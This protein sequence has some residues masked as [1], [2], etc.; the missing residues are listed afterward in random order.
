[1]TRK[2]EGGIVD[3]MR[4]ILEKETKE[5]IIE[6]H[7]SGLGLAGRKMLALDEKSEE[8]DV[9]KESIKK[10]NAAGG[11]GKAKKYDARKVIFKEAYD[12]MKTANG[13]NNPKFKQFS[14]K[15]SK[16]HLNEDW[17]EGSI[18]DW[19]KKLNKDEPI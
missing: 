3:A 5:Q 14:N 10:R 11:L 18:N 17:P 16:E 7:L 2:N 13:G 8:L 12:A 1:M 9:T 15:L 4:Q 19:W 6:R